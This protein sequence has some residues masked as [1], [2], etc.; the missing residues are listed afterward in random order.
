[1]NK[2]VH[3]IRVIEEMCNI[4]ICTEWNTSKV[5]LQF[6]LHLLYLFFNVL[7]TVHLITIFVN[8]LDAQFFFLVFVYSNSP[9]VSSNPVL[10]I[11]R[12]VV[13]IRPLVYVTLCR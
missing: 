2:S 11:R 6:Y 9:H 13:S 7:L 5:M 4:R 10:I 12:V 3:L 1:M 8:Q